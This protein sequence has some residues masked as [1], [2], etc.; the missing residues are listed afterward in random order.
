MSDSDSE[1]E[2]E[3][4]KE[5]KIVYSNV[6]KIILIPENYNELVERF[7]EAFK[8]D[9]TKE[10][11]F[12]QDEIGK[13]NIITKE[14]TLC[15]F[16][17]INIV[18]A[19]KVKKENENEDKSQEEVEKK[20]LNDSGLS[21]FSNEVLLQKSSSE[22]DKNLAPKQD[23]K[24]E[25]TL[26]SSKENNSTDKKS[27]NQIT[28]EQ[29]LEKESADKNSEDKDFYEKLNIVEEIEIK[30]KEAKETSEKINLNKENDLGKTMNLTN[31]SKKSLNID[32]SEDKESVEEDDK[33]MK[34]KPEEIFDSNKLEALTKELTQ[35]N[36]N[37]QMKRQKQKQDDLK[38]FQ[39]KLKEKQNIIEAK[40]NQISQCKTNVGQKYESQISELENEKN[41]LK[42][43]INSMEGNKLKEA[44]EQTKKNDE[45]Q[46]EITEQRNEISSRKEKNVELNAE[47][48]QIS[49][50]KKE[51]EIQLKEWKKKL[52][53]KNRKKNGGN[54]REI[55]DLIL[56]INNSYLEQE[57]E[58]ALKKK[59][60]KEEK[61]RGLQLKLSKQFQ[62][63]LEKYKN[64]KTSFNKS[65]VIEMEKI[66]KSKII[67]KF[68]KSKKSGKE[69]ID[70]NIE[71]NDSGNIDE[72]MEENKI[73]KN[74]IKLLREQK[75]KEIKIK[76]ENNNKEEKKGLNQSKES[77]E[78]EIKS[79]GNNSECI[80]NKEEKERKE[81]I[82]KE[83][84]EEKE[85]I[86]KERKERKEKIEKE[87]QE[88]D[89]F[90]SFSVFSDFNR[91]TRISDVGEAPIILNEEESN[92]NKNDF[93]NSNEHA[94]NQN[95]NVYSNSNEVGETS[96]DYYSYTCNNNINLSSY[97]YEKTESTKI[98]VVIENN[99][100]LVWPE[101]YVKLKFESNSQIKGENIILNPQK[102]N[103]INRYEIHFNNLGQYKE[104]TYESYM[105]CYINEQVYGERL[106]LKIEIKKKDISEIDKNIDKINE[107]RS[108]FDLNE[109]EYSNEVCYKA[110]KNCDNDMELAFSSLFDN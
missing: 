88:K 19:K 27:E 29:S 38:N 18:Y 5:I 61:K 11:I 109:K 83:E 73:L 100:T 102:P 33:Y 77:L 7:F 66:Q 15:D 95:K 8:E 6:E 56:P 94:S 98:P 49:S 69:N 104:G 72:L 106:V 37:L 4:K 79:K 75:K 47:T 81:R 25:T 36:R 43:Y 13:D 90:N 103:E 22:V 59:E 20:P 28:I 41:Q 99:G 48:E 51:L 50:K 34:I 87:R 67:E 105:N 91:G 92:Q 32:D 85:R 80:N 1:S 62:K 24:H 58:K 63:K 12:Y 78:K 45:K 89:Q 86:E 93:S 76:Q 108:L 70:N 107:F 39:K 82:E 40:E 17:H 44:Q 35:L 16:F 10:Y 3:E 64:G 84:K 14:V 101:N 46:K 9:K 42:S 110:L 57:L 97:I 60:E 55:Y 68:N 26:N 21:N 54:S 23:I 2:N 31:L 53:D 52:E 30:N 71:C 96:I 65:D 74:K